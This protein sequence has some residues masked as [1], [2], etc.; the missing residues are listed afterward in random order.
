MHR[1]GLQNISC[2][3]SASRASLR[4]AHS[5]SVDLQKHVKPS[6]QNNPK[7]KGKSTL[8][9]PPKDRKFIGSLDG[10]R[11]STTRIRDAPE[12]VHKNVREVI[13]AYARG[14]RKPGQVENTSALERSVQTS[15]PSLT[16]TQFF[17]EEALEVESTLDQEELVEVQSLQPGTFIEIRRYVRDILRFFRS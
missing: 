16:K 10:G 4:H 8:P 5:T 3:V 6:P 11:R 7:K 15:V 9:P 2:T 14:T 13:K 17:S 12:H 1:R